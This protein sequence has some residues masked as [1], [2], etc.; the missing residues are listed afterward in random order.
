MF[1][2]FIFM[3]TK[4]YKQLGNQNYHIDD[5]FGL[6]ISDPMGQSFKFTFHWLC[7]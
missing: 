3:K 1:Y 6:M 7:I 2:F 5:Q 4:N